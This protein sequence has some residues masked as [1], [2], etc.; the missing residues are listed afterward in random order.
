M[1]VSRLGLS[2]GTKELISELNLEVH[3]GECIGIL[4]P[5]G[6]GK[7]TLLHTL[8]GLRAPRQ[9]RIDLLGKSI[10]E[11]QSAQLA[12]KLGI[13]FQNAADDMPATVYETVAL[14]RLPHQRA[15]QGNTAEDEALIQQAL[16]AMALTE[17]AHRELATLSGGERQRVAIA[18][19]L[20][21]SPQLCLLDE[22]SNHLDISFQIRTLQLLRDFVKK[23]TRALLM[24]THD[25]NLAAR[26]CDRILLLAKDGT[27]VLGSVAEVLTE[28]RLAEAF[29]FAV[30][31]FEQ[32]GQVCF[33]PADIVSR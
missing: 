18:L 23:D 32:D 7:T 16:A 25:I 2:H 24:S 9:G 11:W 19:L 20:A 6:S 28:K 1:T 21:Q 29:S 30:R 8:C 4:G 26:F 17:L 27:Y 5:N 31:R 22:P 14:G 10:T 33:M 13:V 3:A 15:W 12:Q